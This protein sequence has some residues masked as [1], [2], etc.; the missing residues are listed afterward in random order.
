MFAELK[1]KEFIIYSYHNKVT[2][3]GWL[4]IMEISVTVIGDQKLEY[5]FQD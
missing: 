2:Q 4:K 3:N 1:G 5:S